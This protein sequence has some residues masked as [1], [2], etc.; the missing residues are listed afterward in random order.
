MTT[1]GQIQLALILALIAVACAVVG[2]ALLSL[3]VRLLE[4]R[5][6]RLG[7]HCETVH[8]MLAD[9]I[10]PPQRMGYEVHLEAEPGAEAVIAHMARLAKLRHPEPP[11]NT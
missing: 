1:Y 10:A 8:Q 7:K 6:T 11:A 5:I 4:N 2:V 9:E 3:R